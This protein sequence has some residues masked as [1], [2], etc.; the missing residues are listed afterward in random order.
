M[1]DLDDLISDA[2]L[3]L[4]RSQVIVA[5]SEKGR[6]HVPFRSSKLTHVLKDS[7]GG[8]CKARKQL[9]S[10]EVVAWD[11][12]ILECLHLMSPLTN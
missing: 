1:T 2:C 9:A 11:L 12:L 5:L 6:D 3:H 8:N 4:F 10:K 7:L